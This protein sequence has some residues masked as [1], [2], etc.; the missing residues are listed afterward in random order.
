MLHN[1]TWKNH[2]DEESAY[3]LLLVGECYVVVRATVNAAKGKQDNETM[4]DPVANYLNEKV[5]VHKWLSGNIIW[6]E[7]FLW[8]ADDSVHAIYEIYGVSCSNGD[9]HYLADGDVSIDWLNQEFV[10]NEAHNDM[11]CQD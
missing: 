8:V 10:A 3:F 7:I 6:S 4:R 9:A 1:E 11:H 5:A 2:Q